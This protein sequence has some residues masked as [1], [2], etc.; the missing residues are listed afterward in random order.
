[1]KV[2][3]AQEVKE[4]KNGLRKQD[5][6]VGD[7]TG[8][9]TVIMWENNIT[10][11]LRN[12]FNPTY[13]LHLRMANRISP[14][15]LASSPHPPLMQGDFS[16]F[17]DRTVTETNDVSYTADVDGICLLSCFEGAYIIK[18]SIYMLSKLVHLGRSEFKQC[19]RSLTTDHTSPNVTF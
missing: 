3:S 2:V 19:A 6:I 12:N 14:Y 11:S 13:M 9:A 16:I 17:N 1:M 7:A 18:F 5:Y 15:N 10:L 4:V 8:A